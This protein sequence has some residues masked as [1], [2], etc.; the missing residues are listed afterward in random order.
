MN[1]QLSPSL[2]CLS[3]DYARHYQLIPKVSLKCQST[4]FS[5]YFYVNKIDF[6]KYVSFD[7]RIPELKIENY[8]S[9]C[10]KGTEERGRAIRALDSQA[11]DLWLD[12]S[13]SAVQLQVLRSK[14]S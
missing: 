8:Q 12:L 9:S 11:A 6:L 5:I 2:C 10:L 3:I 7:Y 13:V 4:L 1:S 14:L